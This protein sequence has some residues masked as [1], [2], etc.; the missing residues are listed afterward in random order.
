MGNAYEWCSNND[1]KKV[2][3]EVVLIPDSLLRKGIECK[4][5][6]IHKAKRTR[7][8]KSVPD[9]PRDVIFNMIRDH[10]YRRPSRRGVVKKK[11]YNN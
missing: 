5:D 11:K 10:D 3:E 9:L 1:Q 2:N 6:L 7:K 4:E 8:N